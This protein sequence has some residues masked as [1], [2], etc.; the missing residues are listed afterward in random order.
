MPLLLLIL[1][2]LLIFK[3]ADGL[4]GRPFVLAF[5]FL[6]SEVLCSQVKG[7]HLSS[8]EPKQRCPNGIS[9]G[10]GKSF[11]SFR[12]DRL[13]ALGVCSSR[14]DWVD[15]NLVTCA[16]LANDVLPRVGFRFNKIGYW[17]GCLHYCHINTPLDS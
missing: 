4:E 2:L 9:A 10:S 12:R 7:F 11:L 1:L 15:G 3:I 6:F 17:I 16:I 13:V 14:P 5:R 8:V